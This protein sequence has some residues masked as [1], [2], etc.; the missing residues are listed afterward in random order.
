MK[1]IAPSEKDAGAETLED[2][3]W[4]AADQLRANSGLTSAQYSQPVLGLIFLRFAEVRFLAKRAVLEK[5]AS[6]GR[7]GS[8]VDDPAAYQADGIVY[9]TP[10]ARFDHLLRLPEGADVGKPMRNH[11]LM[12]TIARANRVF[13]GKHSGLI[14][15]Y[16]NVFA[17]LE[18]ALAIYA[19]GRGGATPVRD[20]Q[21][22]VEEL[23]RAVDAAT[24]FCLGHGVDI[25]AIES[26]PVASFDRLAKI[27]DA[28]NAV[29]SPD[30]LRKDFLAHA[31]WVTALYQAVKPDPA[32]VAFSG[33]VSCLGL[34]AAAIKERTGGETA[35]IS[36]VMTAING[37]LDASI[38]ADGFT[39]RE[40]RET[41]GSRATIDLSAIDFEALA[42]RFARA[43]HK[44]VELEQLRAAVRAQLE[45]L[46]RVNRTRADYQTKFEELI[47]SYNSGSRN[48]DDLFKELLALSKALSE[49]QERHVREHLTEDELTVFDLLTRPGP[50]LT[51]AERDEVKK[52]ARQLLERVRAALVID[53]RERVQARAQVRDAIDSTLDEG[54]P[55]AYTPDL[56]QRKCSVIFEH[57]FETL[58]DA[59][60]AA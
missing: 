29:I 16:A 40:T 33:R 57:V 50:E 44:N 25:A 59:G 32:V 39:I 55:P 28:V 21:Q 17:S 52:V 26:L 1:W 49:E 14:V 30:P 27:G 3:L 38:A 53:W 60:S 13:P 37:L 19:K 5:H 45:R 31:Q 46:V 35:D 6:S 2:R 41:Y 10:K 7:R 54:L 58:P 12:Q 11:T 51:S 23:G 47:E 24:V 43:Q 15:D 42:N 8:R 22:L 56:Y 48:I 20:K 18:K 4:A 9:L 36:A 34:I